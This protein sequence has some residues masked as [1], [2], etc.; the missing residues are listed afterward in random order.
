MEVKDLPTDEHIKRVA[1]EDIEN[2]YGDMDEK[3][4]QWYIKGFREGASWLK[5]EVICEIMEPRN[6]ENKGFKNMKFP[7]PLR[8]VH[9]KLVDISKVSQIPCDGNKDE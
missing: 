5:E 4:K 1:E 8:T 2:F 7:L 9:S 6:K 3:L